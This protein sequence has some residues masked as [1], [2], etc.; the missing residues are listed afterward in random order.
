MSGG[1]R[2]V[3]YSELL[4]ASGRT[5]PDGGEAAHPDPEPRAAND[6]S[7]TYHSTLTVLTARSS[8]ARTLALPRSFV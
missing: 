8:Y 5:R 7:V 2:E 6:C 4:T 3:W 1:Y